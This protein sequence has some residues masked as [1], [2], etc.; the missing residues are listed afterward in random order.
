MSGWGN[1]ARA[2]RRC[3]SSAPPP[4]R[5]GVKLIVRWERYT[6]TPNA[7]C[8][9]VAPHISVECTLFRARSTSCRARRARRCRGSSSSDAMVSLS[10]STTSSPTR[11]PAAS[12][13]WPAGHSR[14]DRR[15]AR[16]RRGPRQVAERAGH[17]A[18][19]TRRRAALDPAPC[20]GLEGVDARRPGRRGRAAR[21]QRPCSPRRLVPGPAG[22]AGRA[23][24]PITSARC[25]T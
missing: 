5:F 23:R 6:A 21:R 17:R 20:H 12:E 15:P 19:A 7:T 22:A 16:R 25:T 24:L 10:A 4:T 14:P 18:A 9:V 8:G 3:V 2:R 1:R 11:S 13:R